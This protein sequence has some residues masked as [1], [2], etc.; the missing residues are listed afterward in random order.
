MVFPG[1]ESTDPYGSMTAELLLPLRPGLVELAESVA[2]KLYDTLAEI[3][4][5]ASIIA[6]LRP[7]EFQRL[8]QRQAQHVI[9]LLSPDLSREAH[10]IEA[11]RAGHAHAMVGVDALWLVE[12]YNLYQ[13]EIHKLLRTRIPPSESRETLMRVVCQ[14]VL[15]DIEGQMSSYR[16]ID[17]D[18]TAAFSRIDRHVM[19]TSNLPDLIRGALEV[20]GQLPGEI[21][22]FFA[23]VDDAGELQIEQSHGLAAEQ[24]HMAMEAGKV[25]KISID[26]TIMPG[27]GPGGRAWRSGEMIISDA[28]QIE[29]DKAPWQSIGASLGFRSSA[30][31]PLH[32]D[33]GRSIALLSLYSAWPGFFSTGRIR[34]FFSHVQ[35]ILSHAI[36][37]RMSFPVVPLRE[38][39]A[40]RQMLNERRVIMHYQPIID[41]RDGQLTKVE[42]LARMRSSDGELIF[43]QRFLPALGKNEL[44]LLFVQGLEQACTDFLSAFPPHPGIRVAINFPAEGFDDSRYEAALFKTLNTFGLPP[45]NLQLEVLETQDS[46]EHVES[47][48]RF[49]QRLRAA[50]IQIVQDDLGSGH[51]SLLRLEQYPFDEVKIDQGLVRGALHSPKRAVEFILYLTRLAHAFNI[52]VT[53]EGLENQGM[54]EAAAI[55]G[56]DRGQGYGIA[57]PMPANELAAWHRNHQYPVQPQKPKTAIGAMAGYLL[58]D[59]QL[60]AISERPELIAEF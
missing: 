45:T 59:L 42:A 19:S 47:R 34:G 6:R 57:K 22:V 55:L 49:L 54:M 29:S 1:A 25:P 30:A 15:L 28:W 58:W 36:Q 32:D 11:Q 53:V 48:Q 27:R 44:L 8:K 51:S 56:A 35:Q 3:P 46:G 12:A 9:M 38:Q 18:I 14:R 39:Q 13:D 5:T 7:E 40:Y 31:I 2:E 20:I 23:R 52:P 60:A 17:A 10:M 43:P 4:K 26:P 50:G 33:S 37:Q 24:Y 41:L 21:S 16:A